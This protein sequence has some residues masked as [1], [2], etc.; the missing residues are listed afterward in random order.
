[1]YDLDTRACRAISGEQHADQ[2]LTGGAA[3]YARSRTAEIAMRAAT[4]D[5]PERRPAMNHASRAGTGRGPVTAAQLVGD[6][7][8]GVGEGQ[9]PAS[10]ADRPSR[11][12]MR[13]PAAGRR[14]GR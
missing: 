2:A 10:R 3:V 7:A 11:C 14:R 8:I 4:M 5:L 13:P 12:S 6:G 1:M 9:P